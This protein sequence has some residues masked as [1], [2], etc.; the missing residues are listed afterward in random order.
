MYICIYV[1]MYIHF[2]GTNNK[3]ENKYIIMEE[4]I[5]EQFNEEHEDRYQREETTFWSDFSIAEHFGTA[6]IEDTYNRAM[7]QWKGH[8]KY[9]TELVLVLNGKLWHWYEKKDNA[10]ARV[11]EDLYFKAREYALDNLKGE[12]FDFFYHHTD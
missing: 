4:P 12:A 8:Y 10:L 2:E 9:L 1:Y 3:P 7:A 11:Y 6:A 5:Q